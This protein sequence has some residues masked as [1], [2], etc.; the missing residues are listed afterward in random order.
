MA[1][2]FII[3]FVLVFFSAF[4]S[5]MEI[6]FFSLSYVDQIEI[7]RSESRNRD[8][9]LNLLK[10]KEK[11]L[12][13]ILIGNNIVNIAASALNTGL[14]IEFADYHGYSRELTATGFAAALTVV[15]LL[16]GEIIPKN[17]A[18]QYNRQLS[19]L[20][21]PLLKFLNTILT[22]VSA[23]F[24]QITLAINR[25]LKKED[26]SSKLSETTVINVVDKGQEL[27]VINQH[28]TDLIRN[29]FLF[30]EREVSSIMTPRTSVFALPDSLS[31]ADALEPLLEKKFSRVPVYAENIDQIT[32]V[33]TVKEILEELILGDKQQTLYSLMQKPVFIYE[34][35]SLTALLDQFKQDR[36]HMAIV[37]DEFGGVAGIVTM[38]DILEELVGDILDEKDQRT[39]EV[40][41]I[42][43]NKW[44]IRGR[45]DVVSINKEIEEEIPLS[46][47]YDT[48]QGLIMNSMESIPKIGDI[49]EEHGF[50]F[51]VT[52]MS[53]NE[54]QMVLVEKLE[55]PD[56]E[57]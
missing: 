22:P 7:E 19:L 15:I 12:S 18:I 37:V 1:I 4:F 54:V 38:E 23:I 41:P 25:L 51:K 34:T 2:G 46:E 10:N 53:Q 47:H 14:A 28:E 56:N 6:A 57:E 50:R 31:L 44:L 5:G 21:S 27:G 36:K 45:V 24:H 33:I 55:Q 42:E 11:L 17:V 8:A 40:Q 13:T 29:V 20:F 49:V 26:D 43:A 39:I 16:L 32:G 9:L 3:L 30:D 52:Q 48:L 35:I